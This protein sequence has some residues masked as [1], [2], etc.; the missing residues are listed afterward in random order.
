MV[1]NPDG[2]QLASGSVDET[3]CVW[4]AA[5]GQCT[6]TL[7]G[8]TDTVTSVVFSPDGKQLASGSVD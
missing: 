6:A 4:D 1:F 7:L 3:V 5:S 8:H 2:K